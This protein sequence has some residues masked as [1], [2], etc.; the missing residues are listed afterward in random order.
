MKFW[1]DMEHKVPKPNDIILL[2]DADNPDEPKWCKVEEVMVGP[3]E[4]ISK[5]TGT[6][7]KK[8]NNTY[9]EL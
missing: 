2:G 6:L 9:I 5:K 1:E 3:D 7:Y 8:I 4:F